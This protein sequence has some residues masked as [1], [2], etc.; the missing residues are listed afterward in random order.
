MIAD[1]LTGACDAAVAFA[2]HGFRTAVLPTGFSDRPAACLAGFELTVLA[3]FSRNDPPELARAKVEAACRALAG[4]EIRLIYKKIDS[5][6]KGNLAAEIDAVLARGGFSLGLVS[7]AFPAMGRTVA[8]GVLHVA[9]EPTLV[10]VPSLLAAVPLARSRDAGSDQDLRELAAEAIAGGGRVLGVGSGGLAAQL[11]ALLAKRFGRV[12]SAHA[13]PGQRGPAL[14]VIGSEQPATRAQV[15]YLIRN[16]SARGVSL[17]EIDPRSAATAFRE[18]RH[19]VVTA[20]PA[21][22][23]GAEAGRLLALTAGH[24]TRGL[25]VSGGDTAEWISRAG[26]VTAI[27]LKGEV[28]SGIPWGEAVTRSGQHWCMVTKAGGFGAENALAIA[29]DFL[30]GESSESAA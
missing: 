25:V 29:A 21:K 10:D 13:L 8:G 17:A 6:L 18:G 9:G 24:L 12:P 4:G 2:Q 3:T 20:D 26:Q 1:D 22:S 14:F 16:R 30:M 23:N 27:E 28:L 7:P 19:L 11:A 5:T 15:D